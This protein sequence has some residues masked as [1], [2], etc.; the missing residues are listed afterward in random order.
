MTV[1]HLLHII[2]RHWREY[3][4]PPLALLACTIIILL[5]FLSWLDTPAGNLWLEQC[6]NGIDADLIQ[7]TGLQGQI[8]HNM[9][10]KTL[11]IRINSSQTQ[12]DIKDANIT[13]DSAALLNGKLHILHLSVAAI[14]STKTSSSTTLSPTK[15]KEQKEQK[16]F[17][18]LPLTVLIN[19]IH[20]HSI[21]LQ[22]NSQWQQII[23]KYISIK[24]ID[25]TG[26][27]LIANTHL[28]SENRVN[29]TNKMGWQ[30][31]LQLSYADNQASIILNGHAYVLPYLSHQQALPI[32]IEAKTQISN[33]N[34]KQRVVGKLY[35]TGLQANWSWQQSS[36]QTI[37][38]RIVFNDWQVPLAVIEYFSLQPLADLSLG[39]N[40]AIAWQIDQ[41]NKQQINISARLKD[42]LFKQQKLALRLQA[43]NENGIIDNI[44][45]EQLEL[46]MQ[47]FNWT[48]KGQLDK[49]QVDLQGVMEMQHLPALAT[50]FVAEEQ[51]P[52]DIF[53][54]ANWFLLG[55]WR[56]A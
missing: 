55:S 38:S 12:I 54:Q 25:K 56:D 24:P 2:K 5:S 51:L 23:L 10:C 40:L 45:L 32:R 49:Q 7:I 28:Q 20:L 8:L 44:I 21:K 53:M 35:S 48:A 17:Q 29:T 4:Y 46:N 22:D 11:R 3:I 19:N 16:T 27:K 15:Q 43:H 42:S 9:S 50:L 6:I 13:W 1:S 31:L 41:H 39:G 33:S 30:G 52:N 47:N 18:G 34:N 37:N 26:F 36:T 14:K